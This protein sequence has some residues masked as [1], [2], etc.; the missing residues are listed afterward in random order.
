M[1][2]LSNCEEWLETSRLYLEPQTAFHAEFMY[3]QLLDR[4]LY[5]YIPQEPPISLQALRTRYNRL[6]S[7]RSPDG[8][9]GWLNWVVRLRTSDEYIGTVQATVESETT[10]SLAYLFSPAHWGHGYA[11]ESCQRVLQHLFDDYKVAVVVAE[12]DTR[13]SASIALAEKLGFSRVATKL[14]ADFFKD[15]VSHEYR[16]EKRQ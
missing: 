7:R 2:N 14:N 8:Q 15:S 1:V 12:I 4:R 10:A 5:H 13:N 9:E 3:E 16:Y 6:A 11:R